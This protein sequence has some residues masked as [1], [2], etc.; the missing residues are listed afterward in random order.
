[1]IKEYDCR[2]SV[3]VSVDTYEE[4]VRLSELFRK[5]M[6]EMLRD[7]IAIGISIESVEHHG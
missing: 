1:M 7:L 5:S 3:R 2:V 6:S 4:I